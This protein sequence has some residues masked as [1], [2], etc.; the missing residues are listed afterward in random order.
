MKP[1]ASLVLWLIDLVQSPYIRYPYQN[2]Q[3]LQP[4]IKWQIHRE[5][6]KGNLSFDP[7]KFDP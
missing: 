2:H 7:N 4:H 3:Y 6:Q 5:L 1:K